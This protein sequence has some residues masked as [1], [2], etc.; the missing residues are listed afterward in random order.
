MLIIRPGRQL[1]GGP[2]LHR[3]PAQPEERRRRGDP[4]EQELPSLPRPA[5]SLASRWSSAA[6]R[7]SSS[8][9]ETAQGRR[10][11]P[12]PVPGLGLH[13]RERAE[14]GRP[15]CSTS[16]TRLPRA[17]R[18]NLRDL[19]VRGPLAGLHRRRAVTDLS[20]ARGRPHRAAASRARSALPCFLTNGC[21]PGGQ[22]TLRHAAGGPSSR[23]RPRASS[24]CQH[25]AL[26]ARSGRAAQGAPVAVRPRAAR[27]PATE[28]D[29]GNVD[30]WPTSTTSCSARP[31]GPA[32]PSEDLGNIVA[33]I[34]DLSK[35]N[36]VA[37][38]MQQGFLQQLFLGRAMIHPQGLLLQ[39]RVPEERAERDRHPAPVLLRRQLPGRRSWAARL[40]ARRA[41]LRAGGARRAGHEL[42]DAA[43]AQR[44]LRRIRADPL[45][46]LS[47]RDRAPAAGS[48]RSSCSGTAA[49][50]TA[51]RSTSPTGRCRTRPGTTCCMHVA[52]RR[53]PGVR[54]HAAEV[55]ARTFGAAVGDRCSIRAARRTEAGFSSSRR[56]HAPVRGLGDR[57]VG[58]R[59]ACARRA[60]ETLGTNARRRSRK[61]LPPSAPEN[62]MD[63]HG[64]TRGEVDRRGCRSPSS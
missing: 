42:L 31:T 15:R 36:T 24:T 57:H 63:P 6:G 51:T 5:S 27:Q 17:R 62:G 26:G 47:E 4:G 58:R 11:A 50:R 16:A 34:G 38:R 14:P 55:E 29:A 32:S 44:R 43:A 13:G 56:P 28:V 30:R 39:P 37:D 40:T 2:A 12:Q 48:P 64:T 45:P 54:H 49:R 3:G 1:R 23:A 18:P 33:A 8:C 41:G 61:R 9:Y 60:L 46:A 59:P 25:P 22:F 53:P 20:L 21:A 19:K 35:F 52:L 7:T 10:P